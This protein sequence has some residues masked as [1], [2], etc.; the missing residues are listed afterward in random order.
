MSGSLLDQWLCSEESSEVITAVDL[1]NDVLREIARL[2]KAFPEL[3]PE[4]ISAAVTQA[5]LMAKTQQRWN[6]DLSH[7]RLT[8]TG[9]SQASR[10]EVVAY[11]SQLV[12]ERNWPT[13]RV[14]DLG[15]GLGF[16]AAGFARMGA[17]VDAVEL[18][19]Q[20]AT[21]ATWNLS[22]LPCT[23]HQGDAM[24]YEI[25]TDTSFVF[26]DPARRRQVASATGD[27]LRIMDPQQWSPPWSF[28]EE[29][30]ARHRVLAKVAPGIDLSN[31]QNWDVDFIA[32]DGQLVEALLISGGSGRKRAVVLHAGIV[33]RYESMPV[34]TASQLEQYLIAPNPALMRA[35]ALGV[36]DGAL[37]NPHIAWLTS[38]NPAT[39]IHLGSTF[40]ILAVGTLNNKELRRLVA[41]FPA[42]E[43]TIMTRGVEINPDR[44]RQEIFKKPTKGAG[45]LVLGLYRDDPTNRAVVM[46]RLPAD[47]VRSNH[48]QV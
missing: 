32:C 15:C 29:V 20:T 19:Q 7:L 33:D 38:S 45:E 47:Q 41:Q 2:R 35:D 14:V 27:A 37:V 12:R 34:S 13:Q 4:Q 48:Q 26:L 1:A 39:P 8:D 16:D 11:R 10:P 6:I 25:P 5:Q 43:L 9:V 3:A 40:E 42:S 30:A 23:V 18:D 24:D 21:F 36:I 22:E 44:L 17:T 28:V 46:R 31:L